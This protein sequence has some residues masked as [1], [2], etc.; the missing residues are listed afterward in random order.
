MHRSPETLLDIVQCLHTATQRSK[1]I[2]TAC[3]SGLE[4]TEA[5]FLLLWVCYRAESQALI[6]C[7]LAGL[8]GLSKAQTSGLVESLRGQGLLASQRSLQDRRRQM[9]QITP[10]GRQ[11]VSEV[12]QRISSEL[13]E[14]MRSRGGDLDRLLTQLQ[15]L[16]SVV[17]FRVTCPELSSLREAA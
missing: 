16:F 13:Q 9:W 10:A 2:L 7:E 6:Q 3:L 1:R 5:E 14:G 8:V 11:Y 12:S 17:D 4:I 15:T